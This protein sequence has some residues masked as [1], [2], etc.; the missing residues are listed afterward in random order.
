MF[1]PT[2]S[3]LP[4]TVT[5]GETP[6]ETAPLPRFND[7]LPTNVKLLFQFWARL[8]ASV[9][10]APL[11]LFSDPPEIVTAPLPR[12]AELPKLRSPPLRMVPPE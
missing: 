1:P 4:L 11:V 12:A 10:A 9:M 6:S 3:V 2:V 5:V 7:L 8:P